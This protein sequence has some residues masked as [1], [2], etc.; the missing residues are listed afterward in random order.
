V[1]GRS[2]LGEINNAIEASLAE[3]ASEII[4]GHFYTSEKM[5]NFFTKEEWK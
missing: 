4:A 2:Q 5:L 3:E 1:G